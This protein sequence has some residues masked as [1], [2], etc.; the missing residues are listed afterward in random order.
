[1]EVT[2]VAPAAGRK[3]PFVCRASPGA[4]RRETIPQQVPSGTSH[5]A[6]ILRQI[7]RNLVPGRLRANE[8][9]GVGSDR[10]GIDQGS[11]GDMDP[12]S[13]AHAGIKQRAATGA[14]GVVGGVVTVDGALVLA[15]DDAELALLNAGERLEGGA[16]GAAAIRAVAVHRIGERVRHLVAHGATVAFADQDTSVRIP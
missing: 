7:I 12:F 1:M 2:K 8:N 10:G 6:P 5:V 9:V 4:V 14:V 16:G 15:P 13:L 3:A 11:H